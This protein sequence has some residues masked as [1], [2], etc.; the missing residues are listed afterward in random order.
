MVTI[1]K[2]ARGE[3]M[4]A[5]AFTI[6]KLK[7]EICM[8]L[9]SDGY[10]YTLDGENQILDTATRKVW[11]I[12]SSTGLVWMGSRPNATE[13]IVSGVT[14]QPA[15][16]AIN[17]VALTLKNGIKGTQ[18]EILKEQPFNVMT[19]EATAEGI[20]Y[21]RVFY[22]EDKFQPCFRGI[23]K[24]GMSGAIVY[25]NPPDL[26]FGKYIQQAKSV[27]NNKLK[28]KTLESMTSALVETA[29]ERMV[30]EYKEK[31]YPVGG[32]IFTVVITA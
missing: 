18:Y 28:L 3:F 21:W 2:S 13:K 32:E 23:L 14:G 10:A 9:V 30:D 20:K 22:A 26:N 12:G 16:E 24:P 4:S 27:V 8:G 6:L 17:K 7:D 1:Q 29:F 19:F 15:E 11:K 25:D 5:T 31:G